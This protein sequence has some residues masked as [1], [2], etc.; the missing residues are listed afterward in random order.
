M[1]SEQTA[2][3]RRESVRKAWEQK[4]LAQMVWELKES[5]LTGSAQMASAQMV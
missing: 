2:W 1:R 3:I 5:A 4:E